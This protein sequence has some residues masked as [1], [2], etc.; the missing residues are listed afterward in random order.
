MYQECGGTTQQ[1]QHPRAVVQ[2]YI[3]YIP[4]V[5]GYYPVSTCCGSTIYTG[6]FILY[7]RSGGVLPSTHVLWL[8][9]I[10]IIWQECGGTT[11]YP[12][13]VAHLYILY[14]RSV[15]GLP[16]TQYPRAVAQLY[17]YY[18]PGVWGYYPLTQYP[19]AVAQLYSIY[20][21][22]GVWGYYPRAAAQLVPWWPV[23]RHRP[24]H[25][26]RRSHR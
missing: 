18:I 9:Y 2:L 21:I 8:N 26:R 15:G 17:I 19:R 22:P 12:R 3:Y 5:W 23:Y 10:Y 13:A 7:T 14:T 25:E 11:Q 6:R 24:C 20:F 4:G 1:C 16:T